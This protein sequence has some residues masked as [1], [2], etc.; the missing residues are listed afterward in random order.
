MHDGWYSLVWIEWAD[1]YMQQYVRTAHAHLTAKGGK[2]G[3]EK[4]REQRKRRRRKKE[5]QKKRNLALQ[6]HAV[7]YSHWHHHCK[8]RR[9]VS[10]F[11][12]MWKLEIAFRGPVPL[13]ISALS[14]SLPPALCLPSCLGN[15]G[16]EEWWWRE[17]K[18]GRVGGFGYVVSPTAPSSA[19]SAHP[20]PPYPRSGVQRW[21]T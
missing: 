14:L 11:L 5:Q 6:P 7:M 1:L 13:F 19:P 3:R 16:E 4:H 20:G 17:K 15:H 18:G 9:P 8:I 21:A 12:Q 2:K 10:S